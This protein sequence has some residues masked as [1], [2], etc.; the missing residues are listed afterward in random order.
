M[1]GDTTHWRS[2]A[3][4]VTKATIVATVP[5]GLDLLAMMHQTLD[6]REARAMADYN[7]ELVRIAK[8]RQKLYLLAAPVQEQGVDL[9]DGAVLLDAEEDERSL[10]DQMLFQ[11]AGNMT[12]EEVDAWIEEIKVRVANGEDGGEILEEEFSIPAYYAKELVP[13]QK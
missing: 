4:F 7:Q 5:E 11:S 12:G 2:N 13:C 3:I 6:Q 1:Y 9:G 10:F 8:E